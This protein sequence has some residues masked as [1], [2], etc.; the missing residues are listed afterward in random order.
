MFG[1]SPCC[2]RKEA[3]NPSKTVWQRGQ[4]IGQQW[5]RM[6]HAAGFIQ[7]SV[8]KYEN[9]DT[10]EEYDQNI[11]HFNCHVSISE[12][13]L[14]INQDMRPLTYSIHRNKAVNPAKPAPK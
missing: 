12:A 2:A 8:A 7:L 9:S 3:G 10:M 5:K 11:F 14:F 13:P 1:H 4:S 6:N